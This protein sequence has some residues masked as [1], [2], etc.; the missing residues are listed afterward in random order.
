MT[1]TLPP[2]PKGRIKKDI[3]SFLVEINP[4][5]V[6]ANGNLIALDAKINIDDNA[7]HRQQD[8]Q[9]FRDISQENIS[10]AHAEK[11]GLNYI[12]LDGN[13]GC[14]VNG[15]GLAMATMDLVKHHGG[16]PANF[17]DVGGGATQSKVAEAFKL[18]L[19]DDNVKSIFVNIFGGIVRCDLIAQGIL[20]AIQ[21]VELS[22]PV[23]VLLQ[24][25]NAAEGKKL[26][27]NQSA[28]IIPVST[29]TEGAMQAVM[30]ANT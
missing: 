10:E 22:I 27:E 18:V 17:L 14:I 26:L 20:D 7:L 24:G 23:T 8:I 12:K 6:D 3:Q 28:K 4:L 15:A 5:I 30:L 2:G 11:L 25:T 16:E 1:V 19:S 13:I 29:L 9:E 21:E